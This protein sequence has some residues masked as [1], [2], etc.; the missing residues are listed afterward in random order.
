MTV[1][2]ESTL[3]SAARHVREGEEQVARQRENLVR[4][5]S[6]GEVA[7]IVRT[8]LAEFEDTPDLH[9][10]HLA[11]LKGGRLRIGEAPLPLLRQS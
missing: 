1:G 9:P 10:A 5:S 2:C 7:G 8:L 4:L 6:S 3:E 11:R